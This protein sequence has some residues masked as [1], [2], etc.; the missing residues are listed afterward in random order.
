MTTLGQTMLEY[1]LLIGVV[2]LVLVSMGTDFKRGLQSFVKVTSDQLGNQESAEQEFNGQS[3]ILI[4][5]LTKSNQIRGRLLNEVQGVS[6]YRTGEYAETLTQS[7]T[8]VSNP[9]NL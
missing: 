8:N 4:N 6:H 2:T 3:G 9:S 1:I 7:L 5:S